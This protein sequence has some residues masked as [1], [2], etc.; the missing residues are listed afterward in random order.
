MLSALSFLASTSPPPRTWDVP[1]SLRL[2][3]SFG[4][5][6]DFLPLWRGAQRDLQGLL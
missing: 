1:L 4:H 5:S 2:G 3:A 6:N